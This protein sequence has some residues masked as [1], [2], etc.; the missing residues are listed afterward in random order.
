MSRFA[1][2]L[3]TLALA[4]SACTGGAQ[5]TTTP[6]PVVPERT[7]VAVGVESPVVRDAPPPAADPLAAAPFD[8]DT[9]SFSRYDTGRMWTF[10]HPPREY[11]RETYGLTPDDA[12]FQRARLGALRL[13]NCT[14]SFVSPEGLI[15]TNHHCARESITAATREGEDLSRDGFYA[16][17]AG[18]ERAVED[19]Y[20]DQ[21]V[22]I[23]DVTEE[24]EAALA[25]RQTTA[26]RMSA[27]TDRIE[28]IQT[29]IA[30]ERGGEAAGIRVQVIEFYSG[31]L[32][33]AYV[34]R[35]YDD[36][37][38]VLAPES[39]VGY[40][41]GDPDNFT[42]PRYTLDFTLFRAYGRDGQPLDTR[43]H[44]FPWS[45]EGSEEGEVVFVVGN[46]GSTT[47]LQTVAELL[48]RR[49]SLEPAILR[50]VSTR[51]D[52]YEA[53]VAAN[54]DHEATPELRNTFFSLSNARK[55]YTGR[56]AG[57]QDPYIIARR[58][59][60]ERAFAEAIQADPA[61]R[62]EY[63]DVLDR[64][65]RNR[66][67]AAALAAEQGAFLG[68][69][70][71]SASA[72]NVLGRA[73]YAYAFGLTRSEG[74]RRAAL[75]AEEDRPEA[76]EVALMEAKLTDLVHYL[77]ADDPVVVQVLQGRTPAEAARTIYDGTRLTTNEGV[78]G[79]IAASTV[80]TSPD[81]A[82]AFARA[83]FPRFSDYQQR[84][85]ALGAQLGELRGQLAGA[86][87]TFYG[88]DIPPDATFSLRINDGVVRG[89][90]YN[91]TIAPPYTTF[92]GMYDRHYSHAGTA[93][94]EFF[95]LPEQ[96]LPAPDR[97]D[98]S[99]PYNFVTTND[100]IGGNSGSPMLNR[101]LEIV[102]VAF[103]GNIE[104][105]P[106]DYIYLGDLNRTVA[107]DS[108]GMLHAMEVVYNADRIV[109]ELRQPRTTMRPPPNGTTLEG[110]AWRLSAL[111]S[112]AVSVPSGG[113]PAYLLF[114]SEAGRVAGSGGCNQ[115]T[116]EYQRRGQ[117]VSFGQMVSTRMFCEGVMDQEQGLL[118]AV[119]AAARWEIRN[120]TL[121]LLSSEGAVVAEFVREPSLEG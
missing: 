18:E 109:R 44:Y 115:V 53:F 66:Q 90:P 97:L 73:L 99:T 36:I 50:M 92:W 71:G 8:P 37:R 62:Q 22:E 120:G 88:T 42:Y 13:P 116:G 72:S 6:E 4:L 80:T 23:V 61:L 107:V 10:E 95:E 96:W 33:S 100:I 29:R 114:D 77:G 64:I 85:G 81:P 41:G 83:V 118:N 106:G 74:F 57:L 12:W 65:A 40:F 2:F 104:S 110:V 82:I 39:A 69:N 47:R 108:R 51:A 58:Q 9:V 45:A 46:P 117:L 30:R 14:A 34:F 68:L 11:L 78:E 5:V 79:L 43:L 63:G 1:P 54:P 75:G 35:R 27:R 55:A 101:N 60:A 103:D 113:G 28:Q 76:V 56:V 93:L 91:G 119:E 89:Y 70:P 67:E 7:P 21:L 16:A 59:A 25:G 111:S 20:V 121:H 38:L 86:R 52:I 3:L 49:E 15:L 98:L 48:L 26:E 84:S 31:R 94:A 112:G 87:F 32:Y 105:L 19:L 102:G 17:T 24:M